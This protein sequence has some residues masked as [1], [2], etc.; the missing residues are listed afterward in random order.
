MS[1]RLQKTVA[2]FHARIEAGDFYEAHQ[3]LRTIT[4]RYVQARQY[5][6]A[7]ELLTQGAATF[8]DKH[9]YAL[10]ADLI[11]YLLHVYVDAA[12]PADTAAD[13][14]ALA[15]VASLVQKLPDTEPALPDLAKQAILWSRSLASTFGAPS[16]HHL[17]GLKLLAAVGSA[18]PEVR[19]DRFAVAELH[20]TL[21][22][23]EL[24]PLYADALSRW[25]QSAAAGPEQAGV[26]PGQFI[27]RA[28]INYL[29]LKNIRFA[30]AAL[31]HFSEKVAQTSELVQFLGLLV[32]TLQ[33]EDAGEKFLKL[34]AHY[35]PALA[36]AGLVAQVEYLGRMYFALELGAPQKNMFADLMGG[37]FK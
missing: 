23:F 6:L 8:A 32:T 17:F 25:Y 36:A 33:K 35:K 12:I 2:R 1:D 19:Q 30:A 18:P 10:A 26:D 21:G 27:A 3:T 20:L 34:Y 24:V 14:E 28:V 13:P 22:T 31:A 29:Y 9:E 37:L 11:A 4:N 7:I 16:L 5:P 15:R